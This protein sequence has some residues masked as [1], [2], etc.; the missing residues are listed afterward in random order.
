[1]TL[2]SSDCIQTHPI[3][4]MACYGLN[5]ARPHPNP[6][7]AEGRCV[8]VVGNLVGPLL[9]HC[10]P[11]PPHL[12]P[13]P[14]PLLLC[15][16]SSDSARQWLDVAALPWTKLTS[17]PHTRPSPG[18]FVIATEHRLHHVAQVDLWCLRTHPAST[19]HWT[20]NPDPFP[21]ASCTAVP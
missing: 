3:R 4:G 14:T 9:S 6:P 19:Q 7:G 1:M 10:L 21:G 20:L 8:V 16:V 5:T 12:P 11:P 18:C 2:L 13:T 17:F 15:T